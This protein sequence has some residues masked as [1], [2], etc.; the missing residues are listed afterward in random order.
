MKNDLIF[1]CIAIPFTI[2]FGIASC[3]PLWAMA[4]FGAMLLLRYTAAPPSAIAGRH[5]HRIASSESNSA[6]QTPVE[7]I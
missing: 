3:E 7:S 2:G 6:Y 5:R 1:S 4:I